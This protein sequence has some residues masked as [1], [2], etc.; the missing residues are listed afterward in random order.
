MQNFA[1]YAKQLALAF[2]DS[3]SSKRTKQKIIVERSNQ[4]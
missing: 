3:G 2:T 1:D 4:A